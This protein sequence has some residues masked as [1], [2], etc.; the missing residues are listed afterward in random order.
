M[1]EKRD[2]AIIQFLAV[3]V[4][5]FTANWP[6]IKQFL[7]NIFPYGEIIIP[8]G[9]FVILFQA[10]FYIYIH[11]GWR[12]LPNTV[13]LGGQWIYKTNRAKRTEDGVDLSEY[14]YGIFEIIHT[15]DGLFIKNGRAWDYKEPPD[16]NKCEA[17]WEADIVVY[18]NGKLWM[19]GNVIS[20]G[21]IQK[22]QFVMLDVISNH[23]MQ[24]VVW[25]I[26]DPDGDYAYGFTEMKKIG[27]RSRNDAAE[28]ARRTYVL[29]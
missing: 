17:V 27:S 24:G 19:I 11:Y 4:I 28:L 21:R 22:N 25:G 13:W 12:S 8:A 5:L 14:A 1:I 29:S 7:S 6:K 15:A 23:E 9:S 3:S 18:R 16:F 26:L 20:E 2:L 10:L